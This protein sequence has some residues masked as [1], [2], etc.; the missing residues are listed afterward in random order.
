L[1]RQSILDVV[2]GEVSRLKRALGSSPEGEKLD[3]HLDSIRQLEQRIEQQ[4]AGA[5]AGQPGSG[6]G[7]G[8]AVNQFIA[9]VSCQQPNPRAGLQDVENSVVHVELAVAAFACDPTRVAHV[10]FGHHQ[11][12]NIALPEIGAQ[13]DWH[14]DFMHSGQ[15]GQDLIHLENWLADRFADTIARLKSTNAPDGQGSLYDQTYVLWAREMGNGI[16]HQGDNMP[17]VL[18]GGAGGYLTGNRGRLLNGGGASHAQ[19]LLNA[20]EAMGVTNFSGFGTGN[21]TPFAGLRG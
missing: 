17:Y 10:E 5:T 7:G 18:S 14:N 11:A 19:L 12:C 6:E 3:L 21:Q 16:S 15:R 2:T 8:G 20:A 4:L 1:R 13:G 9:P